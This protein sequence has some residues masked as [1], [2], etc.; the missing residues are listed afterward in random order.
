MGRQENSKQSAFSLFVHEWRKLRGHNLQWEE[1]IHLAGLAWQK[2]SPEERQPYHDAARQLKA[3][4]VPSTQLQRNIDPEQQQR[5]EIENIVRYSAQ[6]TVLETQSYYFIMV[7]YYTKDVYAPAEL[8]VVQFTLKHGLRNIYHTLINPGS[9]V[10]GSLYKN[11]Q[12]VKATHQLPLPPNALGNDDLEGILADL[13]KFVR[14]ECGPEGELPPVFTVQNQISVVNSSLKFLNGGVES[15][16]NVYP[17]EYLFYIL[18]KATCEAGMLPPP[19]SIHITN[20]QFNLDPYEFLSDIGCEFHKQRDLSAHCSKS[21]VTRWAFAFAG[22]M[23]SDLAIK[24][25]TNRH[26]PSH[27][28]NRLDMDQPPNNDKQKDLVNMQEANHRSSENPEPSEVTH[29][30]E[31]PMLDDEEFINPDALD[32]LNSLDLDNIFEEDDSWGLDADHLKHAKLGEDDGESIMDDERVK[33]EEIVL[34]K[35]D[36]FEKAPPPPP[37]IVEDLADDCAIF[38]RRPK[39]LQSDCDSDQFSINEISLEETDGSFV[40]KSEESE[41]LNLR[42]HSKTKTVI[43]VIHDKSVSSSRS[44][45]HQRR[46][47]PDRERDRLYR[48]EIHSQSRWRSSSRSRSRSLNRDGRRHQRISLHRRNARG[49]SRSSNRTIRDRNA[50]RDNSISPRRQNYSSGLSR[51]PSLSPR[52][53]KYDRKQECRKTDTSRHKMDHGNTSSRQQS[54]SPM[55]SVTLK[56]SRS[57][58]RASKQAILSLRTS[59]KS[60]V[61]GLS[62]KRCTRDCS[63]DV[64]SPRSRGAL[65]DSKERL[66]H[67][68]PTHKHKKVQKSSVSLNEVSVKSAIPNVELSRPISQNVEFSNSVSSIST[69]SSRFSRVLPANNNHAVGE[70][71]SHP[72]PSHISSV[73]LHTTYNSYHYG[74]APASYYQL[75]EPMSFQQSQY[76]L[77]QHDLRHR[78]EITKFN[79]LPETDLRHRLQGRSEFP[80]QMVNYSREHHFAYQYHSS[81]WECDSLI[82]WHDGYGSYLPNNYY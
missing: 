39:K 46:L 78:L 50:S 68:K 35:A 15:Q 25:L 17:I 69:V 38:T 66:N 8:A 47:S 43:D 56:Y 27:T 36:D 81:A 37:S 9:S 59:H 40:N 61:K 77:P 34:D 33:I 13:L 42:P 76:E 12:H 26:M 55:R 67:R 5:S 62:K 20:S 75:Q 24:M 10:H 19:A 48:R 58:S 57:S 64:S 29:I 41:C 73:A 63:P 52:R 2:M 60:D 71:S 14:S 74:P 51:R 44:I 80:S 79:Y 3:G 22:Y 31:E 32:A 18:K 6:R 4:T 28:E 1:C 49:R 82:P 65:D 23:C 70:G 30:K 16:F 45:G 21:Y 54:I 11:Q 72:I 53:E 7:N